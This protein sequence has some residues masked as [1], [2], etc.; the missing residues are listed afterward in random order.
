M[1][2]WY[3]QNTIKVTYLIAKLS[4]KGCGQNEIYYQ[5]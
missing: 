5:R 2:I 1:G 3:N 4:A